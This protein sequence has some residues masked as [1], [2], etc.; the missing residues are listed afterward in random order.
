MRIKLS[1]TL[2]TLQARWTYPRNHFYLCLLVV[3]SIAMLRYLQLAISCLP[4]CHVKPLTHLVLANHC[5][6]MLS[7]CSAPLIASLV[8]GEDW[9]PFLVGTLFS[10]WDIIILPCY[11][12]ASIY[13]EKCG[14]LGLS[15]S[16]LFHSCHPSFR[17]IGV[18]F[19]DCCVP[20]AVGLSW[21][22][23]DSSPWLKLFQQCPTLV[24]P[25]AT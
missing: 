8:A 17:H 23:L 22:P 20:Y 18:M 3:H 5:L 12:N 11:L 19:P 2:R 25:F 1:T 21:E 24:L 15:P 16:V 14:R 7:L 4:Y 13:L 9:R 6:A 10:C